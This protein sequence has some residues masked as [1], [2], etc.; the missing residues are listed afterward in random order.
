[1]AD[2]QDLY[3]LVLSELDKV[4]KAVGI[5]SEIIRGPH[6]DTLRMASA[7]RLSHQCWELNYAMSRYRKLR[8]EQALT[9]AGFPKK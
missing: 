5:A 7:E 2:E 8:L 1:M 3:G 4:E 9:D 6:D